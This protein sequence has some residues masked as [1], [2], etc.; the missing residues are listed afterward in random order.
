MK[1]AFIFFLIGAVA[2]GITLYLYK[3]S[4]SSS[5]GAAAG[6]ATPSIAD[7]ARATAVDARDSIARKLSEWELDTDSIKRDLA[8]GGSIVR[9]KAKVAGEKI[10]DAR[11]VTVI[12]AKYVLERDLSALDINIDCRDGEVTLNGTVGST[13]LLGRAVVLALDTDGVHNVISKLTLTPP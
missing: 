12:K 5:A 4:P 2:G 6:T 3:D 1:T 10:A 11:I 7:K 13:D 8:K 9:S